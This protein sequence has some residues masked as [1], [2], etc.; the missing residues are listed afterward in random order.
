M[1]AKTLPDPL[2]D[3]S[4]AAAILQVKPGTLEVW[5]TTKRYPLP[6]VK[7]GRNVR[8][9]LSAIEAFLASRTVAA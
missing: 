9:R 7:V 8:Y 5:R 3:G 6:Y 2:L 4:Q 1:D